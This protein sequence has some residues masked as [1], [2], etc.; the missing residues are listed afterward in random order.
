MTACDET[1]MCHT[2]CCNR[3]SSRSYRRLAGRH[4]PACTAR[5]E[6]GASVALSAAAPVSHRR[7][8]SGSSALAVLPETSA[9][10]VPS[11]ALPSLTHKHLGC[12]K[13]G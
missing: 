12:I 1:T 6:G 5:T 11:A 7:A 3:S 2:A 4:W 13:T 8:S 10:I 9:S